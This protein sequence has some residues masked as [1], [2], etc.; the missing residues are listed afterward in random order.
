VGV[1]VSDVPYDGVPLIVGV[2]DDDTDTV[3][4]C[5]PDTVKDDDTVMVGE[6]VSVGDGV[7]V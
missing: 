3:V 4:V 6:A 7:N 1:D 2:K 5:V